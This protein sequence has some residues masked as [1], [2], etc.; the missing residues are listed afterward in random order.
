MRTLFA[1]SLGPYDSESAVQTLPGQ[2]SLLRAFRDLSRPGVALVYRLQSEHED[3]GGVAAHFSLMCVGRQGGELTDAESTSL[4]DQAAVALVPGWHL[5]KGPSSV[6]PK[7]GHRVRLEPHRSGLTLPIKADWAPLVDLIRRRKSGVAIDL[8]CAVVPSES[9]GAGSGF[10]VDSH[11][12]I[13]MGSPGQ[14]QASQF[15]CAISYPSMMEPESHELALSLVVHAEEPPDSVFLDLV[16]RTVLGV[17]T[18]ATPVRRGVLFPSD[19]R[20]SAVLGPPEVIIRAFHPPYGHIE[21]RGLEGRSSTSIPIRFQLPE[22]PDGLVVGSA[23]QQGPGFDEPVP[24]EMSAVDRV[25]H[26]Y[27]LGKTGA[28][29]TNFLKNLV[30]QDIAAGR[31][32][33]IIDPHGPL[34]DYAL[35]HCGDRIDDVVLLDFSDERFLPKLNPLNVDSELPADSNKA[36][37]ELL[38]ILVRK[39]FNQFSGPVFEDTVHTMLASVLAPEV[40]NLAEP[41]V[42]AAVELLRRKA[43]RSWLA[44]SIESSDELKQDWQTFNSMASH[45]V[46]EHVRWVLA[47]FAVFSSDGPLY[48]VSGAPSSPLSFRKI[49]DEGQILLVKIPETSLGSRA[50]GIVGSIVFSRLHRAARSGGRSEDQPFMVYLDEF[51]KF[52]DVELEEMVAEARKF[53]L[54]LTFAHQNTRQLEA[55]SRYEGTSNP[56]LR[57]AIFSNVG[58]MVCMKTSGHDVGTI[59]TEFGVSERA[60]RDLGQ[61]DALVRAVLGNRERSPFVLKVSD[62]D[63]SP[64]EPEVA[65]LIRQRMIDCGFWEDRAE[66]ASFVDGCRESIRKTCRPAPPEREIKKSSFVEDWRRRKADEENRRPRNSSIPQRIDGEANAVNSENPY[67]SKSPRGATDDTQNEETMA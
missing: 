58:T 19:Q 43:A 47:K 5:G 56:R 11:H 39:T 1:L 8:V 7:P 61:Y 54:A 64:G 59:A 21:G 52:V 10:P 60:V 27:V 48:A 33:A 4:H 45:S 53:G 63:G 62:S 15:F 38:D 66:L 67:K 13:D 16:G 2:L 22:C 30:R 55:F 44:E 18:N 35:A 12:H 36:I 46:A 14:L 49:Y 65:V 23:I 40:S 32:V 29:K 17:T 6:L 50:S 26:T 28:G 51:Q 31:G 37:D 20:R 3:R 57:E 34:V 25:K 9:R 41:S 42:P 24:I